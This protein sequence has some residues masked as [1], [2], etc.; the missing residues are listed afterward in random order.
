MSSIGLGRTSL[1]GTL[2][3]SDGSFKIKKAS[4]GQYYWVII[5]AGN[6]QVL[7]T[8]ETYTTKAA[9][10]NGIEACKRAVRDA[11]VIDET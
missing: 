8:S 10:E 7:A 6:H 11:R 1:L 3:S 9:A 4:N 2:L 5:S